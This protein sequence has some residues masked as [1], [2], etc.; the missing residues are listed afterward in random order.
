MNLRL[1]GQV[2]KGQTASPG[3]VASLS[4]TVSIDLNGVHG[5]QFNSLRVASAL[6]AGG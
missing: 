4:C 5:N 1:S 6:P 3:R 2:L